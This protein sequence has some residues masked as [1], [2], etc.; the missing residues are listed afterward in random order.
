ME[1][2]IA[3]IIL[4]NKYGTRMGRRVRFRGDG[5]IPGNAGAVRTVL[6]GAR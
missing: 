3:E 1:A 6:N 2:A 5:L 4:Q